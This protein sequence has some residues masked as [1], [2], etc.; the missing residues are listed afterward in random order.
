MKQA[1][2]TITNEVGLHARPAAQ[3][4][5]V[6]SKFKSAVSVT[7]DGT[8]VDGRSII[9][10][11]SLGAKKGATIEVEV[12]GPDEDEAMAAIAE[13]LHNLT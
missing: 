5:Q 1:A 12:D 4:V 10:V 3:F 8:R 6:T 2:F 11:L 7:K 13:F 9:G